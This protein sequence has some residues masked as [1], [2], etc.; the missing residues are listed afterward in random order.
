VN[1][2]AWR[3]DLFGPFRCPT[4][5]DAKFYGRYVHRGETEPPTC[6]NHGEEIVILVPGSG[7]KVDDSRLGFQR[8]YTGV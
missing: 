4:C 2:T 6:P 7:A 8:V 3:P 5:T 1:F